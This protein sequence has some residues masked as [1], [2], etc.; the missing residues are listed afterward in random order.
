MFFRGDPYLSF[1]EMFVL[2]GQGRLV[3]DFSRT[4]VLDWSGVDVA[5]FLSPFVAFCDEALE[6][7]AVETNESF[8]NY[9]FELSVAAL[10]VEHHRDGYTTGKPLNRGF[11]EVAE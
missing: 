10:H 9:G 4:E 3:A 6:G 7:F 1:V 11:G 2:E 5:G 8:L